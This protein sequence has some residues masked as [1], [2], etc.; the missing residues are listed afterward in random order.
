MC[1]EQTQRCEDIIFVHRSVKFWF[2]SIACTSFL[3]EPEE[4]IDVQ[5]TEHVRMKIS[6]ETVKLFFPSQPYLFGRIVIQNLLEHRTQQR[7]ASCKELG[8][9]IADC[10]QELAV[11]LGKSVR[12]RYHVARSIT[13]I[14]LAHVL[15]QE[16]IQDAE[17][18][19]LCQ[20]LCRASE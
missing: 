8:F 7:I 4:Y 19:A 17:R 12:L 13:P 5:A 11:E 6:R 14:R 15:G 16:I 2:T 9:D 3:H 1:D 18:T 20:H 10:I